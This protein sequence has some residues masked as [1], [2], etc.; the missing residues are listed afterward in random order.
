MQEATV[1]P[2]IIFDRNRLLTVQELCAWWRCSR[3][4]IWELRTKR[5]GDQR[6]PSYKVANGVRFSYDEC[7]W[8]LKKL[9]AE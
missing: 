4:Y 1:D 7:L 6:L 9:E 8:Y 2:S 5:K 3:K